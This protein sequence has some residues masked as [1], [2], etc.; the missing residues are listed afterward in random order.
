MAHAAAPA[1]APSVALLDL[2]DDALGVAAAFLTEPEAARLARACRA[3]RGVVAGAAQVSRYRARCLALLARELDD[4]PAMA[5]AAAAP[6]MR[7]ASGGP[8]ASLALALRGAA[9]LVSWRALHALLAALG[10]LHGVFRGL[11]C[12]SARGF[13]AVL[14]GAAAE[15]GIALAAHAAPGR[16]PAFRL[17]L[18]VHAC[19]A[20]GLPLKVV[21]VS[22][23]GGVWEVRGERGAL[24]DS[25]WWS[26]GAAG[27]A[28]SGAGAGG[29]ADE[30]AASRRLALCPQ[31]L[32]FSRLSTRALDVLAAEAGRAD[33]GGGAAGAAGAG[34]ALERRRRF[35]LWLGDVL[36]EAA[37]RES[38][39]AAAAVEMEPP[40]IFALERL[41]DSRAP[42][43]VAARAAQPDAGALREALSVCGLWSAP[44]GGHGSEVVHVS[45]EN[46]GAA[47][48]DLRA[49]ALE[50]RALAASAARRGAGAGG[51]SISRDALQRALL[52]DAEQPRSPAEAGGA[53]FALLAALQGGGGGVG[54]AAGL[55]GADGGGGDEGALVDRYAVDEDADDDEVAAAGTAAASVAATPPAS[56]ASASAEP[57]AEVE[58]PL[59]PTARELGLE[60]VPR[61][62]PRRDATPYVAA[63][64]QRM[65][66]SLGDAGEPGGAL[67]PTALVASDAAASCFYGARARSP[68]ARVARLRLCVRKV[69]GDPNVPSGHFTA[70]A[71]IGEAGCVEP[72]ASA[73]PP[74]PV[75]QFVAGGA[76]PRLVDLRDVPIT[77]AFRATAYINRMPSAFRAETMGAK[78]FVVRNAE[79]AAGGGVAESRSF[80]LLWEDSDDMA[81]V[82]TFSRLAL[83]VG[84]ATR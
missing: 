67:R 31:L 84:G 8:V 76:A 63:F 5:A 70:V 77:A 61:P 55:V 66:G 16:P 30:G 18:H 48:D 65:L 53:L 28:G 52:S 59:I 75:L 27:D 15:P 54:G 50:E 57:A 47:D 38:P 72:V 35:A 12:R 73:L 3:L 49:D 33:A 6:P 40:D 46:D 51:L 74:V 36:R 4:A 80:L 11:H 34:A 10:P 56:S 2:P 39:G 64:L 23:S 13:L 24:R 71:D 9:R 60:P 32:L 44:Y 7:S 22:A 79:S 17:R 20:S 62:E 78:L 41:P 29:A 19:A 43:H 83:R 21:A 81:H 25:A 69:V 37:Q 82:T 42:A 58:V 68:A 26:G 14:S 45:I 1:A